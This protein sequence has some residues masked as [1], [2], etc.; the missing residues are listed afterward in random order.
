M[1]RN[2]K[3]YTVRYIGHFGYFCNITIQSLRKKVSF[4]FVS[5]YKK[6]NKGEN[7]SD[8]IYPNINTKKNGGILLCQ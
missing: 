8:T 5:W 6:S 7:C 1:S 2:C 3:V 4:F